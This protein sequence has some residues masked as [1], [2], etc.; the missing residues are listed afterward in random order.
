MNHFNLGLGGEQSA[1]RVVS[2]VLQVL[3]TVILRLADFHDG[4][5][6]E[7]FLLLNY[8][9]L[10]NFFFSHLRLIVLFVNFAHLCNLIVSKVFG[11]LIH[12]ATMMFKKSILFVFATI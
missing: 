3:R 11:D 2:Q 12:S 6:L 4:F 8:L 5:A 9:L 10:L 1:H 7:D